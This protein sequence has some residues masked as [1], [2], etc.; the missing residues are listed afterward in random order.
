[1][2]SRFTV[3]R[4]ASAPEKLRSRTRGEEGTR[5]SSLSAENLLRLVARGEN[6]TEVS[7]SSEVSLVDSGTAS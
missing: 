6:E 1:M 2:T 5:A 4:A 7:Y 3:F